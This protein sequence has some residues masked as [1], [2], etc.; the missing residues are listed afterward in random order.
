MQQIDVS[1]PI[2]ALIHCVNYMSTGDEDMSC[3]VALILVSHIMPMHKIVV[4]LT[5]YL[6]RLM[7]DDALN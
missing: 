1:C 3:H 2:N 6:Q 4:V 5:K 7:D